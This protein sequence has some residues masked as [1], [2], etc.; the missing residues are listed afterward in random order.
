MQ[1]TILWPLTVI[2]AHGSAV[3]WDHL[4]SILQFNLIY[5]L[6]VLISVI[7]LSRCDIMCTRYHMHNKAV[8]YKSHKVMSATSVKELQR[9][10]ENCVTRVKRL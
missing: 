6:L 2:T 9:Y 4:A 7:N 10:S 5:L 8:A 3:V 1:I